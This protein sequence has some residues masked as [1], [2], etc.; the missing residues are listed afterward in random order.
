MSTTRASLK[1]SESL[2]DLEKINV[3]QA[4]FKRTRSMLESLTESLNETDKHDEANRQDL[5]DVIAKDI[6]ETV[7]SKIIPSREPD[8]EARPIGSPTIIHSKAKEEEKRSLKRENEAAI[9]LAKHGYKVVQNPTVTVT[10]KNPDYEIED[11]LF[12][13]YAPAHG[14]S[15]RNICSNI[16]SKVVKNRQ[17]ERIV[18]NLDDW[19][20]DIEA[21]KKQLKD[22][23]IIGLKEVII[24]K[25]EE[26]ESIYP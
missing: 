25:N 17:A 9:A 11:Q 15:V 2:S 6:E 7:S 23:Q 12:D 26:V 1:R 13:C 4:P 22:N 8:I 16:K 24:V 5:I 14:T 18:L 20:G 19:G 3:G 21:I 10:S